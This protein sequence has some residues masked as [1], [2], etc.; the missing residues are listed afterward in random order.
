M[1]ILILLAGIQLALHAY[2]TRKGCGDA[3]SGP[4][5]LAAA[6]AVVLGLAA[7]RASVD[8]ARAGALTCTLLVL[9]VGTAVALEF[10]ASRVQRPLTS[11]GQ[12]AGVIRLTGDNVAATQHKFDWGAEAAAASSFRT[13]SSVY[14]ALAWAVAIIALSL[15]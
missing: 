15:G 2:L 8:P 4:V 12:T 3:A 5:I 1:T 13:T 9:L 6:A 7:W 10:K 14:L 11:P